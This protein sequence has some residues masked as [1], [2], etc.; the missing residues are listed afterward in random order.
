MKVFLH[1]C[2]IALASIPAFAADD[3]SDSRTAAK[4]MAD[5]S[6]QVEV[7]AR[8]GMTDT[9]IK[10]NKG[11]SLTF[12]ASGEWGESEGVNRSADGGEAGVL[13]T[14]YWLADPYLEDAPWGALIGKIGDDVFLIGRSKTIRASESGVLKLSI[15]D[16]PDD[17]SDNHGVMVV[18]IQRKK[19][20]GKD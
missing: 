17:L 4:K 18:T 15:N 12:S 10:V 11:D 13:G 19:G 6:L 3:E 5:G 1:L 7:H 2:I 14:G 8:D 9:G 16:D 20:Q